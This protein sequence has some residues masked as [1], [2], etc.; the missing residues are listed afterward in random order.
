MHVMGGEAD[1]VFGVFGRR[2]GAAMDRRTGKTRRFVRS[3]LALAEMLGFWWFFEIAFLP[4][5]FVAMVGYR[6]H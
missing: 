1:G 6:H 2:R 5:L 3:G 4:A